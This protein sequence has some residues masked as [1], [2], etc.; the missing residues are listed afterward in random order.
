MKLY[1]FRVAEV[2]RDVKGPLKRHQRG[3]LRYLR[4]FASLISKL[5]IRPTAKER[6]EAPRRKETIELSH[7]KIIASLRN[8][9]PTLCVG[10]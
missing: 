10:A 1:I 8:L 5:G 9:T 3:Q 2:P 4:V 7:F 6:V